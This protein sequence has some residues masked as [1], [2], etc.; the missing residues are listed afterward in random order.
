MIVRGCPRCQD[1]RERCLGLPFV[2]L[3]VCP[4]G[5]GA[6]RLHQYRVHNE[7]EQTPCGE[8]H[9]FDDGP[10]HEVCPHGDDKG[11][12]CQDCHEGVLRVLHSSFWGT[13]K[14]A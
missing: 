9:P 3:S 5:V 8:E 10:F 13:H 6:P 14:V 11:P 7:A 4:V 12:D 2:H 1:S